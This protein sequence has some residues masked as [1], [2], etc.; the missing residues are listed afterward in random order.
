M[1]AIAS[2]AVAAPIGVALIWA[3]ILH[4]MPFFVEMVTSLLDKGALDTKCFVAGLLAPFSGVATIATVFGLSPNLLIGAV[5]SAL[6]IAQ[7]TNEY[8]LLWPNSGEC[9]R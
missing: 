9:L 7:L 1:L 6:G 4:A 5:M 8:A 2:F 3:T